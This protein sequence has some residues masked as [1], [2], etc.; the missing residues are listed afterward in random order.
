MEEHAKVGGKLQDIMKTSFMG[1][2]EG[3]QLS[4]ADKE[5]KEDSKLLRVFKYS[6]GELSQNSVIFFFPV[7]SLL[8]I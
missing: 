7:L 1:K 8:F 4:N 2:Q 5:T 3:T 6:H